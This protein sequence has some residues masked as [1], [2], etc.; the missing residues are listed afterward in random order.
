MHGNYPMIKSLFV[1]LTS[2][3]LLAACNPSTDGYKT[4]SQNKGPAKYSFQYAPEYHKT[5]ED[6]LSEVSAV[7]FGR[8][9]E[10]A[11]T[12]STLSIFVSRIGVYAPNA[13]AYMEEAIGIAKTSQNFQM[14]EVS[15]LN[16]AGVTGQKLVYSYTRGRS[17]DFPS[18]EP[19]PAIV[20]SVFFEQGGCVW[21]IEL[22][23]FAEM[24]ELEAIEFDHVLETLQIGV[25]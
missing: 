24:A 20:R 16:I 14:I 5:I 19:A 9:Y 21:N 11:G 23:G 7:Y 6:T 18:P 8:E 1:L 15:P 17:T 2:L 10:E 3:L 22:D 4:Y 12:F 25:D 13:E